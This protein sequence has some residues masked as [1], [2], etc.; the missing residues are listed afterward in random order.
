MTGFGDDLLATLNEPRP[1]EDELVR[2]ADGAVL[3]IDWMAIAAA[4]RRHEEK[5]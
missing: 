2:D 5:P 4:A 3:G 1:T